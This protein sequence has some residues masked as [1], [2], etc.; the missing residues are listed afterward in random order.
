MEPLS[1]DPAG[2]GVLDILSEEAYICVSLDLSPQDCPPAP[3]QKF[4]GCIYDRRTLAAL[5][6]V[7]VTL[8][9]GS[10]CLDAVTGCD[11]SF[12][13]SLPG[14]LEAITL[15]LTRPGYVTRYIGTVPLNGCSVTLHLTSESC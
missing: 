11:G 15:G 12:C 1:F 6:G 13:F 3:P 4:H 2:C 7:R 5:E 8:R 14:E 10:C 9:Y